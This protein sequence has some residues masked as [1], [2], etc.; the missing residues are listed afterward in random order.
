MIFG[1]E[2]SN[3]TY[4]QNYSIIAHAFHQETRTKCMTNQIV[5][6]NFRYT[7][8]LFFKN[9]PIGFS[10]VDFSVLPPINMNLA[11]NIWKETRIELLDLSCYYA[12]W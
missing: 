5:T 11:W 3:K 1:R 10:K 8:A 4:S 7:V 6:D 12:Y 9:L 2:V